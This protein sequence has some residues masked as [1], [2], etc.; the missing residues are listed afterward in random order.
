MLPCGDVAARLG[1]WEQVPDAEVKRSR[2]RRQS[3][4]AKVLDAPFEARESRVMH[5]DLLGKRR[6]RQAKFLPAMRN[7]QTQLA[8]VL[9]A[10]RREFLFRVVAGT[11]WWHPLAP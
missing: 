8:K 3:A 4:R 9:L 10:R 2:E 1:R 5:A 6:K 11:C 7:T